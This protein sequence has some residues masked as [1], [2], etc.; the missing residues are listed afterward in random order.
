[1]ARA[2]RKFCIIAYDITE[3]RKRNKISKILEKYGIRI[4]YS[5]FECMLSEGDLIRIREEI[6]EWIDPG[7]DTVIY[8]QLCVNCF[9]K[10]EYQPCRRE[11]GQI[12]R[13]V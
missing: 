12:I 5:V 4:N 11:A 3:D 7:E 8:Y 10:I 13:I 9:T 2:K 6:E 1:M